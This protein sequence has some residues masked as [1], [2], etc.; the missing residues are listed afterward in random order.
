MCQFFLNNP[1]H[2][3][4]M[5]LK[6]VSI[7]SGSFGFR[8]RILDT[9]D[10]IGICRFVVISLPLYVFQIGRVNCQFGVQCCQTLVIG[11][12]GLTRALLGGGGV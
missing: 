4:Y 2:T 11:G 6:T 12:G 3:S 8:S 1:V 10:C 5:L 9:V 7:D